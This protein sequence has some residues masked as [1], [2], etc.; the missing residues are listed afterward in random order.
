MQLVR[1]VLHGTAVLFFAACIL[2][3]PTST[4][5]DSGARLLEVQATPSTFTAKQLQQFAKAAEQVFKIREKYAPDVR[6][7]GTEKDARA[8]IETAQAEMTTAI[9]KE[10]MTIEQYN[11][12]IEAAQKD[13][14]LAGEIQKIMDKSR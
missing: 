6:A 12:I 14:A 2:A 9:K 1:L 8:L 11:K 5:A 3:A 7:A 13:P 10:G 4:R